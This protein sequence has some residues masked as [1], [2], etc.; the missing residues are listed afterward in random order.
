MAKF[1]NILDSVH[2]RIKVPED[3]CKIII[4][5]PEFQR[6]RR[7]E[8]NSCRSVYP[9]AR[10]DRFIHSLGVYHIGC[11]IVDHIS[12]N[13]K[14]LPG[15]WEEVSKIYQLACLLHDVGHTPFSHTFEDF[16]NRDALVDELSNILQSENFSSDLSHPIDNPATHELLSAWLGIIRFRDVFKDFSLGCLELFVRMIIGLPYTTEKNI[17][18]ETIFENLMIELIHGSIDADGLDYVCRDV[19]A[20]GYHNFSVDIDRLV[21]GITIIQENGKYKLGFS[22]KVLNEIDTVLNVKNFQFM[23]VINHHKVIL[24]QHYL[25]EGV[26]SAAVYHLGIEDRELAIKS[27]CNFQTFIAPVKYKNLSYRLFR[28]TDDDFVALMKNV[29]HYDKYIHQ[30]FSRSHSMVPLWKSKTEFF[31]LFDEEIEQMQSSDDKVNEDMSLDN[32]KRYVAESV[33]DDLCLK[34]VCLKLSIP[35]E[36]LYVH[37]VKPRIKTFNP[38]KIKVIVN[39]KIVEYKRFSPD[40]IKMHGHRS[41]FYFWYVEEEVIRSIPKEKIISK[42]KEHVRKVLKLTS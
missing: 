7:I 36:A 17:P 6:L 2:G 8:Q 15:N 13:F 21:E 1:K 20:G 27:L 11:K 22:S 37:K 25:V 26:K 3:W 41:D 29:D 34:N 12:S 24:E 9:S 31:H 30:W 14:C 4:D 23:Y 28:P 33:N 38:E 39:D 5:T 10:H 16:Y 35:H 42:I 32:V 40:S 18:D 19:W